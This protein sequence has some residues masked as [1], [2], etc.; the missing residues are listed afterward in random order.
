MLYLYSSKYSPQGGKQYL[1]K[2]IWTEDA[3]CYMKSISY[4]WKI[5]LCFF[6]YNPCGDY[7][8]EQN[9]DRS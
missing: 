5:A 7:W 8:L 4:F 6:A 3:Q 1:N 9:A 2:A